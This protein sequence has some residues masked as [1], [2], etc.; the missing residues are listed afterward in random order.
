[1]E[2]MCLLVSSSNA[3]GVLKL[4]RGTP[5]SL[6]WGLLFVESYFTK[7]TRCPENF[8]KYHF[9]LLSEGLAM[10]MEAIMALKSFLLPSLCSPSL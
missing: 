1:M 7:V 5:A 10:T 2:A 3:D 6:C 8:K 4:T 9:S